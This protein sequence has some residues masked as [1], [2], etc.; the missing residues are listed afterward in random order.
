METPVWEDQVLPGAGC[1]REWP[2]GSHLQVPCVHSLQTRRTCLGKTGALASPK[3]KGL[4]RNQRG[5]V[6]VDGAPPLSSEGVCGS[7]GTVRPPGHPSSMSNPP[8]G[9][10]IPSG[11]PG[12]CPRLPVLMVTMMRAAPR[13]AAL[14]ASPLS[15]SMK[16][17]FPLVLKARVSG[18]M[19][20]VWKMAAWATL[21]MDRLHSRHTAQA[22]CSLRPLSRRDKMSASDTFS[23][24][25]MP[26][27]ESMEGPPQAGPCAQR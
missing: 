15:C 21:C 9:L 27:C 19:H 3:E 4:G 23:C 26:W 1:A 10:R 25:D 6:R 8:L 17:T 20:R 2:G 16:Q 12:L 13:H 5:Q 14:W 24:Q 7:P 18:V 22:S 11:N